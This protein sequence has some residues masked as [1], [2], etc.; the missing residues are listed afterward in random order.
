MKYLIE[1]SS[2]DKTIGPLFEVL[3]ELHAPK[4]TFI[5]DVEPGAQ[6]GFWDLIES[7]IA[8]IYTQ[9]TLIP[10]LKLGDLGTY[11]VSGF[12]GT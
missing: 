3:L 2:P 11:E 5:P 10:R 12:L 8:D 7:L 6:G 4:M 1:N 9:A